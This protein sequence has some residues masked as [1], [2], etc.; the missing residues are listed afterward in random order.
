MRIGW[1]SDKGCA[2]DGSPNAHAPLTGLTATESQAAL[3]R[4]RDKRP[5]REQVL[6]DG[7]TAAERGG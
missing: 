2:T 4:H 3:T 6:A 7:R 5:D 1:A